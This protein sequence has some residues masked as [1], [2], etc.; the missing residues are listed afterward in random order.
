M[1]VLMF[2]NVSVILNV[3]KR[4]WFIM[5]VYFD[6]INRIRSERGISIKGFAK[7]LAVSR[8]TLWKWEKGVFKISEETLK[9]IAN[10]L[11]VSVSDI[12]DLP[13]P[14]QVSQHS[15]S[16]AVDSWIELTEINDKMHQQQ[17]D[18]VLKTIQNLNSRLNQSI[19]IIKALLDSMETMFYVKDKTLKY[20]T[21][22]KSFLENV[23]YDLDSPLLGHDDYAFFSKEEAKVNADEDRSVLQTGK[24][25]LREE[26]PIPGCRKSKWGIVSKLPVFDSE[27]KI[28]GVIGTIVDITE[29]KK[30]E[31]IRELLEKCLEATTHVISVIDINNDRNV[32]LN[33]KVIELLSGYPA[34]NFVGAKGR[35]F[36]I[37][38]LCHPD[39]RH[40]LAAPKE[41]IPWPKKK[42]LVF[43]VIRAD[44]QI[45][46]IE[47]IDT[48]MKY[49]GMDCMIG[50]SRDITEEKAKNEK[51]DL[52]EKCLE[53]TGHIITI[54]EDN[55]NKFIYFAKHAFETL[56]GHTV[57]E[58]LVENGHD[59]FLKK[60]THPDDLHLH[61]KKPCQWPKTYTYEWRLISKNGDMLWIRTTNSTIK[62]NDNYYT[63][64]TSIDITLEN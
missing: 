49:S 12:S 24:P 36:I 31:E 21:A 63:I 50:I 48:Y 39:D 14:A 42:K 30:A 3:I 53:M 6:V 7:L 11:N 59:D 37:S 15:F 17:I 20:L 22:N 61:Y 62:L 4:Q 5:K 29:R 43:R 47:S 55:N 51:L 52:L 27:N 41:K 18:I 19:L 45:R 34:A 40:I 54:T 35:E 60:I 44:G 28:V 33:C 58:A 38:K 64:G 2:V 1:Y 8:T 57:D 23:S 16:K 13:E 10:I 26:R 46:F 56:T 25:V 9:K 32:Y